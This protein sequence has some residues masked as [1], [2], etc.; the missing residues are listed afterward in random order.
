[1]MCQA[2]EKANGD[3]M[4]FKFSLYGEGSARADLVA[5][6]Q[7]TEGRVTVFS[8]VPHDQIP[9]VLAQA[10]VGVTA[11][12]SA[13]EDLFKASSPIKLFEYMATGMPIFATRIS[14]HT[15]VIGDCSCAFWAENSTVE[16][17]TAAL[18]ELWDDGCS[19]ANRGCMAAGLVQGY[20]WAAS[21]KKLANALEYGLAMS[22]RGHLER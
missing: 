14:C 5:F 17:L 12:F 22:E 16:G 4:K 8:P 10:H 13:D 1:M 3:H 2:V 6:S 20:T 7:Q 9:E 11:L 19:L 21:A 18:R 15:D